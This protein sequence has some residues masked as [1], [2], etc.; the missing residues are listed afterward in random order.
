MDLKKNTRSKYKN[1]LV[2][3][4]FLL[5]ALFE[6]CSSS[7]YTLNYG[8]KK[9]QSQGTL[10]KSLAP[11]PQVK[12]KP[13][14]PAKTY[15]KPVVDE[16][17]SILNGWQ[18]I[19]ASKV[20]DSSKI[21]SMT[22]LNTKD[23][24]NAKVPGTI[25][26]SL[27][28]DGVY[29]NPYYGINNL[30]I[31]DSLCREKW[32]Y[33]VSF[34]VPVKEKGK[35]VWLNFKGINY[36]AAIWLNGK[37]LGNIKGAFKRG[38]F[39]ATKYIKETG[40]NILAVNIFPPP[41]PGIPDEESPSAGTGPN[42]GQLCLDGPTFICT[43][44]WDWIPGIRD[45][46]MGIWQNVD[47]QFSGP[48]TIVDPQ[49]ISNLPLPDTTQASLTINAELHN[50]SNIVQNIDLT[51][52]I[53]NIIFKKNVEVPADST[54]KVSF[55][56]SH[57]SQLKIKNPRLWWPNGYGNP[58][59]YNLKLIA[60]A[61]SK[62]SDVKSVRFGIRELSYEFMVAFPNHERKRIEFDPVKDLKNGKL[63]FDN[64]KRVYVGKGTSIPTL[65]QPSDTTGLHIVSDSNMGPY[66]IIKV[67][68]KKIFCRGGNWGMDDAMK[69]V[70]RARLE[71]YFK[72]HKAE[73]FNMI[74]NWTGESTE[75]VFYNLADEYG[76]LVW[77]DFW[78]S[79]QGYNLEPLDK[80]LFIRNVK[81][82]VKRFRN[83][84]SIAIWCPRNE[85]Y[86]PVSMENDIAE[87][88]AT[89]DGTRY[90]QP[91]SRYMNLTPSG[92][93]HYFK[94]P[95][96]YFTKRA[97]GFDTE[98]GTPSIPAAS[99]MKK[100]MAAADLWPIGDVWYYH[101][102]HKGLKNYR[103][104]VNRLY[105]K[106]K[107]LDD[108]CKKMQM[109]NYDSYRAIFESWNSK[110]WNN[111][112]GVLLWMSHPAWPSTEWQTYSWDYG[113]FGS[114]YGSQKACEPLHIQMNLNDDKVS[115]VNSTLIVYR[116]MHAILNLYDLKGNI[117]Y[118]KNIIMNVETNNLTYCFTPE[119]PKNLPD[120]YLVRLSL[121]DKNGKLIS[122]N[123][124]WKSNNSNNEFKE[125][126][127]LPSIQLSGKA[128]IISS[129]KRNE[130]AITLVN[131]SETPAIGVNLEL[132]DN[133]GKVLLPAY[134]S[135]GYFNM[136]PGEI[137]QIQITNGKLKSK[138]AGILVA[139]YNIG[140]KNIIELSK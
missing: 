38:K 61:N 45:R 17:Y 46:D 90:Y 63:I 28:D 111:T 9:P 109:I 102:L 32:W 13:K 86:A 72:L 31:P 27:V 103:G 47:L 99:S 127:S 107:S 96:D 132:I 42:G 104:A 75:S 120:V 64:V 20:K 70:S 23:W 87:I 88:I 108:F 71:P 136:L 77:N 118:S 41:H 116:N 98:I 66:L 92:P 7:H 140:E 115:V 79:T 2:I 119:F 124:Y 26:T 18:L 22:G 6:S 21:I 24:Y 65:R 51:G 68:G 3:I 43:E 91:N 117:L 84:P 133:N 123:D 130:I 82:V 131:K 94:N 30:Y 125:F 78:M 59:L 58:E 80:K 14:Y 105:G 12:L 48:V 54:I 15:L 62:Q 1:L 97:R 39:N 89:D 55:N 76:M 5:F 8:L 138:I 134:F 4:C 53:E 25:L 137:K 16:R 139:G 95:A 40:Q 37:H 73:H 49:V 106:P 56:P 128:K 33:R 114:F 44:G 34:T 74:R 57:Y 93:W 121:K 50:S 29:P 122:Q 100:M 113:T 19:E 69:R 11:K 110:L 85:G 112:S 83:H 35:Q 67:N 129:V 10:P 36:E 81:D 52:E 126:N 135:N 60:S 101:D